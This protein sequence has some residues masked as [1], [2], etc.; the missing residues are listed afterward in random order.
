V[1]G[2]EVSPELK[3]STDV[4]DLVPVVIL[5]L[6]GQCPPGKSQQGHRMG[7]GTYPK[8]RRFREWRMAQEVHH[9]YPRQFY[10][11]RWLMQVAYWR[12]DNLARNVAGMQDAIMHYLEN[13]GA[14]PK[15]PLRR[16]AWKA[17][18]RWIR[19]DECIAE[20]V[21]YDMG[22]DRKNPRSEVRLY[23]LTSES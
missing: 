20:V 3:F 23:R 10:E 8:S 21:W 12:G 1:E 19:D 6:Q 16:E 7:G 13:G 11:G 4:A 14:M 22:L 9:R 2:G 17:R 15:D 5:M 18:P